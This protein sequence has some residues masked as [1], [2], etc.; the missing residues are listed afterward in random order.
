MPNEN[1]Q[2]KLIELIFA[3]GTD[4]GRKRDHNEDFVE[5]FSPSDPGER[6]RKG[7]LFIVADGMGGHQA[8]EVASE[9][10]VRTISREYY[11]D[12]DPNIAA[13]LV[14]SIQKANALI[15]Q[16]AQETLSQVGMGTTVVAA[17]AHERQLYLANVGDSRAYLLRN[18]QLRQVTRDHSFV[19]EQIRAG[20]LS[21][22]EARVHP[23]RNVITRALGV[24]PEV[25]V[26]SYSGTLV[27]GDT[28]LLCSDGLSEPVPDQD[29]K[30]ILGQYPPSEA[31][32]RLIA[33]ANTNGGSDNITALVVEASPMPEAAATA[34]TVPV[35]PTAASPA[36]KGLSLP[37]IVG[38]GAG[39]LLILAGLAAGVLFFA[40]SL[41]LK[42]ETATPTA[43]PPPTSTAVPSPLPTSTMQEAGEPTATPRVGFEFLEPADDAVFGP[44]TSVNFRWN[45]IGRLPD[46]YDFVVST[47]HPENAQLC[48]LEQES[49]VVSLDP[50]EYEWWVEVR[51]GDRV[52]LESDHRKLTV[53]AEVPETAEPP[54]TAT[55]AP[56]V[57]ETP[58]SSGGE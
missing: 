48:S 20:I 18:G 51:S 6:Q 31:V 33:L 11:A 22:E 9:T 3:R 25:E 46:A 42:R 44:G 1:A 15:Y 19:E 7:E 40:P 24:K 8:G 52:V 2:Q 27:P 49:C 21:R 10:A 50:G 47:D 41:G 43:T 17:V 37:V 38:L 56:S 29:I 16:Q 4:T 57:L 55:T 36:R 53:Q 34:R 39:S 12:P 13:T 45:V 30:R 5:A 58:E 35:S 26:D 14:R 32:P 28:L 23:Q 54:A